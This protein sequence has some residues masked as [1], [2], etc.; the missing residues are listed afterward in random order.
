MNKIVYK[1]LLL[2]AAVVFASCTKEEEAPVIDSV[3]KNMVS[4]PILQTN[5]AYPGQTLCL[6]GSGFTDLQKI[7]VNGTRIDLSSSLVY[8]T[9]NYVTFKL[10]ADVST[11][12]NSIK[13]YTLHGETVYSPFVIKPASEQPTITKFSSTTLVAGRTLTITGT[14]LD[15]ATEVFLPLA[16]D[17][18]VSCQI[19][20]E[21]TATSISVMIP[22]GVKFATG[23]CVV[24][25]QKTASGLSYTEHVYSKTTDFIN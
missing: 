6:H 13:L 7:L 4:E 24:A 2:T 16:F 17:D 8:D 22:D 12:G 14:N 11:E 10:P 9:D 18:Q 3:W 23:K 1:F 5:Y 15:G 25:M 21:P 20:S 19:I